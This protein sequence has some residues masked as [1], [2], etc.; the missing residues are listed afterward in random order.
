[1]IQKTSRRGFLAGFG[2]IAAAGVM[3]RA[4]AHATTKD[5]QFGCAAITWGDGVRQAIDDIAA[6]GFR[7]IQFRANVVDKLKPA[8]LRDLLQTRNLKFTALSSGEVML[9]A[10][11]ADEIA[12]HVANAQY[13]KDCGGVGA[14]LRRYSR[15]VQRA[16]QGRLSRLGS[17]GARSRARRKHESEGIGADQPELPRTKAR[18]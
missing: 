10:N 1:M 7:G 2:A 13:V 15:G 8:E 17:C 18:C 12:R 6:L 16:Q 9:D 14:R 3:P 4:E 5:L 11:P